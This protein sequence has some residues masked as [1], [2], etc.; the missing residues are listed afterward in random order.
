MTSTSGPRVS[1]DTGPPGVSQTNALSPA[2]F[3]FA[4]ARLQ[5]AL[6]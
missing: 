4:D 3:A 2:S 1:I 5:V 6:A